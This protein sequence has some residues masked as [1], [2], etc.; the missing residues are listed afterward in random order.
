MYSLNRSINSKFKLFYKKIT[1]ANRILFF[2]SMKEIICNN[3]DF[4]K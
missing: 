2:L 1:V 4:Y 3:V